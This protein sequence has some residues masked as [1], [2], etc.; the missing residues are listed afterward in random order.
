MDGGESGMAYQVWGADNAVYGPIE[1][2]VLLEWI[3]E[4]RVIPTTWVYLE[5][6]EVWAKAAELP[7][8]KMLFS[9]GC[10]GPEAGGSGTT[11]QEPASGIRPAMLRRIKILAG[12][13]NSELAV[14]LKYIKA[15]QVKA[16]AHVVHNGEHGDS[17]YLILS[18]E[19]RARIMI[20]GKE[21]TLATLGVGD[22]FG[23]ISLLDE[24]PRSA[25]VF[26]NVEST[27]L[28]LSSESFK[29]LMKDEPVLASHFMY[30]LGRA[31]A[32]KIRALTKRYQDSVHFSRFALGR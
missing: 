24:G 16:F 26:A 19:L 2:P 8:L 21:T 18:G 17:M 10:A 9:S 13:D 28:E 6:K 30:A 32:G 5:K 29:K 27:V 20:D 1:L 22:F 31:A 23:E 12:L 7:E 4:E 14:F 11:T 25:D 3:K 15:L